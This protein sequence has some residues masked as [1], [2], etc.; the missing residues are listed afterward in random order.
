MGNR[1]IYRD[2][3]GFMNTFDKRLVLIV[4]LIMCSVF[5]IHSSIG[6]ATVGSGYVSSLVS[7][8]VNIIRLQKLAIGI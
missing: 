1:D 6:L 7:G 8:A 2:I 5:F 3:G 4:I